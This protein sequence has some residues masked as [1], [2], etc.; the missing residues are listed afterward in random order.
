MIFKFGLKSKAIDIDPTENAYV[1]KDAVTVEDLENNVE[2]P[3]YM[4]R[5]ELVLFL[6]T[7]RKHGLEL[8]YEVFYTLSYSG[9][10]VG[11]MCALKETNINR[12]M[13]QIKINKTLYNP[14][15]NYR[16]FKIHTPK[17]PSSIR[18]IDVEDEHISMLDNIIAVNKI[19]KKVREDKYEDHGFVFAKR[20]E[21]AGC[22]LVLKQVENR[23]NRLLRIA[24]LSQELTPHSLRHTHTSLLAEAGVSLEQI[25]ARL[26]HSDD[27]TTKL[28][29]LHV[30]KARKKEASQKFSELMRKPP[31]NMLNVTQMLPRD[32]EQPTIH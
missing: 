32:S 19:E 18:D 21:Y 23:M 5:D 9:M 8:D 17:T 16:K 4:E 29:Y 2:I 22:P 31:E 3:K 6:D 25:M 12:S 10:R 7:A 30:T 26:G 15:N 20:G 13:N 28:I 27:K 14:N 24:G 11:E 1:P